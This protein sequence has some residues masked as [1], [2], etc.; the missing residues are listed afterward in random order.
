VITEFTGATVL[1]ETPVPCSSA[2]RE[3]VKRLIAEREEQ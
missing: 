2:A 1:A 3:R